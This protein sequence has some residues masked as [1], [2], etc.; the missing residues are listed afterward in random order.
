MRVIEE[1][2]KAE[3]QAGRWKK[4]EEQRQAEDYFNE[5]LRKS[6]NSQILSRLELPFL[7]SNFSEIHVL[8][9]FR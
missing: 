6:G 7:F 5:S 9:G 1:F 2:V 3:R 4:K 8:V